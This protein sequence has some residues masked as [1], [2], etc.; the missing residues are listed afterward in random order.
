MEASLS[1][2]S[3]A[4]LEGL[5]FLAI[6][7]PESLLAGLPDLRDAGVADLR[8]AGLA[9]LRDAGLADPA[10]DADRERA[11][12]PERSEACDFGLPEACDFGLPEA[13][14]FGDG[15]RDDLALPEAADLA[16][17]A[18][19]LR[20]RSDATGLAERAECG[21][22]ECLELGDALEW[23]D[24]ALPDRAEC[25]DFALPER[26]VRGVSDL[27]DDLRRV[28]GDASEPEGLAERLDWALPECS[29]PE[30]CD[31]AT[32]ALLARSGDSDLWEGEL[33]RLR[34]VA[35]FCDASESAGLALRFGECWETEDARERAEAGEAEPEAGLADLAELGDCEVASDRSVDLRTRPLGLAEEVS[36]S[37]SDAGLFGF[38]FDW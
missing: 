9:D 13:W 3:L 36:F 7:E 19:A 21:L 8:E 22:P 23:A 11:A 14:D 33:E 5:F 17:P 30:C 20:D 24:S 12:L 10:G 16:E 4:D 27:A 6:G 34:D 15:E 31:A 18:E 38:L 25:V 29:L 2:P 1:E 32:L 37:E 35:D 28:V 26:T